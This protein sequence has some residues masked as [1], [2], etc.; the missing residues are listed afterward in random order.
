MLLAQLFVFLNLRISGH[1][2]KVRLELDGFHIGVIRCLACFGG[3]FCGC[4]ARRFLFLRRFR[5]ILRN[6]ILR[7]RLSSGFNLRR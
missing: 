3:K 4:L 5:G 6:N 2:V 1:I 7:K